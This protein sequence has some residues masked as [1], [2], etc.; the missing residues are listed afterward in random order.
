MRGL[1]AEVER[2]NGWTLAEAA[3]DTGPEGMQRLLN[4]YT[5]DCDGLRNDVRDVVVEAIGDE[6]TGVLIVD[7]TGF[8]K[9]GNRSAGVARQY[10]GTAGRIE[11]SQIG[12]FLAYASDRGR[13]L[14]D[15]EL[16]LPKAWTENRDRCRD[17]G[18]DDS[19]EFATKPELAQS[20]I[21]RALDAGVPFGWVTADEAYGQ[22]SRLR[23]WL[24]S[25]GVAHVLAVPKSQMVVSMQLRQRRAHAVIAELD[26]SAWQTMSC[27]DGAHGPRV[28]DWAAAP[29]RP[30]RERGRGHWLLAR[31]S[32]TDPEQIAYY[33]CYGPAETPLAELVRVAGSR[34]AIE[35]CFQTAK[36]E[37]GLDHYQVR[38]YTA[39]YRHITLSMAAAAFLTILRRDAQKGDLQ[40]VSEI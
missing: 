40:P 29:I 30:I 13:A 19:I 10:S 21:E 35:E 25:R 36:N 39:W 34:W 31:R 32:L 14:I 9:K 37:T 1:L 8:L 6:Q 5:W 24:E 20:M 33:I 16:Y 2:K 28:Y 4:F 23:M 3:G 22:V 11:N 12:V 38:G 26:E 17:A 7:E 18:I 27:G 15:R